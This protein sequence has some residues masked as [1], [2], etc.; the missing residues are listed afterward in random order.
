MP[1]SMEKVEGLIRNIEAL[2]DPVARTSALELVK[3]LMEFHGAGLDRMMETIADSGDAGY[4]IFGKFA[5]DDLVGSLLLLY[6][7]HPLPLEARVAQAL[8]KVRPYLDSHGGD[9]E[10]IGIADD[11]VQLR[12]QGSCKT[13]P[14]SAMTLKLAI[15]EAIYAAAPD[16]VDIKAEGVSGQ[17]AA[18]GFVQIGKSA[19]ASTR[20]D[21]VGNEGR[22]GWQEVHELASLGQSGLQTREVGGRDVLFCRLGESFYAYGN[23]CPGCGQPLHDAY[24]QLTN[25]ACGKCGQRYDLIRAGRG[26]DQPDLHL[27]PFPLLFEQGMAKVALPW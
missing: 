22:K 2:P 16:V 19:S 6:G 20:A 1:Q 12:L 26:L 11:V 25:L 4:E 10:L 23:N 8:E 21:A 9:V 17:P 18:T 3:A 27:E 5:A 24:L 13:C 14:S 7:L 15:E